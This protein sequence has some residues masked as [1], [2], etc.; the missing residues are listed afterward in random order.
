MMGSA[1]GKVETHKGQIATLMRDGVEVEECGETM[2]FDRSNAE[3][4]PNVKMNTGANYRIVQLVQKG[5]V[6]LQP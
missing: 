5:F 6:Q 3:L 4:L 1:M 2:A